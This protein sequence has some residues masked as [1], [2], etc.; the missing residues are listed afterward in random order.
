MKKI[1]ILALSAMCAL[2]LAGCNKAGSSSSTSASKAKKPSAAAIK[3]AEN[4]DY[5]KLPVAKDPVSKKAYDFGGMAVVRYDWW[6]NPDAP[7]SSKA[8]EDQR[9]YRKYL[10]ETYNFTYVEDNL[11]AG[12][13][14]HPAEVANYCITGG[15]DNRIFLVD[16]RSAFA[17]LAAN[18]WADVS[19]VP[20]IDWTKEKWN[21]AVLNVMPGKSFNVGMPEPRM[22]M[23]WNKR[24]LQENGFDPDEPYNLQKEGKWTWEK[25]EEM[26]KALTKDT[27]NDGIIDQYA[28]SGYHSVFAWPTIYSN[29]GKVVNVDSNGK[30]YLD[31]SDNVMEAWDYIHRIFVNY[32]K[33][34]PEGADWNYFMADFVN[35]STAFYN[36]EEYD[37][38]VN[39][40][41][42]DMKDDWGMV[43][44]P[45]GPKGD[46]KYFTLNND[47]MLIIPSIYP[48]EKVNKIM[49]IYDIVTD[50][51]PGYD[52]P[53]SWKE[54]YYAGFRD[55]RAV[56]ET[57][58][59]M[60]DNSKPYNA[61]L[62]PNLNYAPLA[63]NIC[64]G[65][66]PQETYESMKNELQATIDEAM[67]K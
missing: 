65:A 64:G 34:Q 35:G 19:K 40:L 47:H 38:Q 7:A 3:A 53:D 17:G 52:D 29:G 14:G 20:D 48:Q 32:T 59:L 24:I 44:I 54:S 33:P 11:N 15:D 10:M 23:F 4:G 28:F 67:N 18:L 62:I 9:A 43:C 61:W 49:K 21:K 51:V 58:Q 13:D 6:S 2:T 50:T 41:L 31:M 57:M 26:C 37:A 25:F 1:A 55:T 42:Y 60:M 22:C 36:N 16:G 66:D 46:G 30:Y 5:S 39:G 45:I 27:D 12:W 8:E 56:D 63:W